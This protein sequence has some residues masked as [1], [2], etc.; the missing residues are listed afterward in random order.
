MRYLGFIFSSGT[1]FYLWTAVAYTVFI[2]V[3]YLL[4]TGSVD[5]ENLASTVIN[6]ECAII[7]DVF[8][9]RVEAAL[10]CQLVGLPLFSGN[11]F[12]IDWNVLFILL[13]FVSAWIEVVRATNIRDTARNDIWSL[14]VTLICVVL[15]VGVSAYGTTAFMIV[16]LVGFGDVLLDRIVGQAVARRDFGGL[17]PGG[18]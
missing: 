4:P 1:P 10:S 18:D 13:G 16:A 3:V 7:G 14:I 8:Y 12:K 6:N 15:F 11:T 9:Q 2:V 17:L 5:P